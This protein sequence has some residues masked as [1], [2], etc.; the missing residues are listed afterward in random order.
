MQTLNHLTFWLG[1]NIRVVLFM[2]ILQIR[3]ERLKSIKIWNAWINRTV[4]SEKNTA[5]AKHFEN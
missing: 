2:V 1:D 4:L 5:G 3:C